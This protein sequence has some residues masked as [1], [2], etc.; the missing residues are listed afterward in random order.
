[1]GQSRSNAV[2]H[3]FS[4]FFLDVCLDEVGILGNLVFCDAHLYQLVQDG[5][6]TRIGQVNARAGLRSATS[7]S[8][9]HRAVDWLRSSHMGLRR[10]RI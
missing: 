2:G 5:S 10:R 4:L 1:M 3:F 8:A 7:Y 9:G 6:Q